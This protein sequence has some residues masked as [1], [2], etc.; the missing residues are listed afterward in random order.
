MIMAVRRRR[1]LG[2]LVSAALSAAAVSYTMPSGALAS[3]SLVRGPDQTTEVT[4]SRGSGASTPDQTTVIPLRRG[5]RSQAAA[6]GPT[7]RSTTTA[8]PPKVAILPNQPGLTA[9]NVTPSDSTGAIGPNHYIEAINSQ[10]GLFNRNLNQLATADLGAFIGLTPGNFPTDPQIEWDQQGARWLYAA[11]EFT[12]IGTL[13]TTVDFGWSKSADPSALT[14]NNIDWCNF[15]ISTGALIH[16]FPRLGHDANFVLIGTNV[17]DATSGAFQTAAVFAIVKPPAG[18]STCTLPSAFQFGTAAAP[19]LYP[20]T[21]TRLFTPVPANVAD[22]SSTAYIVSINPISTSSIGLLHVSP[23]GTSPCTTTPCLVGDG[24]VSINAWPAPPTTG[25]GDWTIAQPGTANTLDALDG[26]LTQAV[27]VADP[28]ASGAAAIWTQHTSGVSSS[29]DA[30]T[31]VTWY[32]L[33]PGLC[34]AGTCQAAAKRQEGVVSDSSLS[35]FNAAISPDSRG[36]NAVI[37][38]NTGSGTSL[39]SIA[40]QG[41]LESDPLNTMTGTF[42]LGSSVV[43]DSDFTCVAPFG[44][45]CRW[46]DYPGASP[47]P[48]ATDAVWGTNMLNGGVRPGGAPSWVT[49]NFAIRPWQSIGG[50]LAPNTGPDAA[51]WGPSR[52]DV[53]GMGTTGDLQHAFSNGAGFSS[54]ESLGGVLTSAPGAVSWGFNR[55]DVVVRGTDQQTWHKWWDGAQWRGWEPLGGVLSSAPDAAAW[56]PNRLDLFVQG[57]DQQLW[58]KWWDGAQWS[59]WEPLGGVLTSGAGAVSWAQN[60]IDVFVRGT[61]NQVWHKWWAGTQWNGWEPLGGTLTSGPDAASCGVGQLDVVGRGTDNALYRRSFTG[62]WS[63]WQRLGGSWTG[64]PSAVCSGGLGLN[65]FTQGTDNAVSW[66]ATTSR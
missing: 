28:M 12:T 33:L 25:V 8:N 4:I 36:R 5:Q 11:L 6:P 48:V 19:L 34:G 23:A 40:A 3:T 54:W 13:A 35:V 14:L 53:F 59:G 38:F 18:D 58:H 37:N 17:F 42:T 1:F 7:P 50:Q 46:G 44:P 29:P 22:S 39:V 62:T 10:L 31:V 26:R 9:G 63:D 51:S 60:R 30:G 20:G 52:L 57:T 55:I 66:T 21:N 16:D 41:R 15:H 64:D 2:S 32:E 56:A 45:P 65:L 24:N 61:D 27:Q 47:D 43:T 49:R